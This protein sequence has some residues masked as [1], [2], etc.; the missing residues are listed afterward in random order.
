MKP[1]LKDTNRTTAKQVS[2]VTKTTK[3]KGEDLLGSEELKRALAAAKK[4]CR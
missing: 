1:P 4:A 2:K 3:P